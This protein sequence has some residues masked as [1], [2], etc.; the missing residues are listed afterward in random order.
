[1][2]SLWTF[3]VNKQKIVIDAFNFCLANLHLLNSA[4]RYVINSFGGIIDRA[5]EMCSV[6]NLF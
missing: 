2:E 1:M 6:A 3:V 5:N 4:G